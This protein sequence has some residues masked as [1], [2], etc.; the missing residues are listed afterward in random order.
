MKRSTT[1]SAGAQYPICAKVGRQPIRKVAAPT[2]R[3]ENCNS[4]LRPYLSP[5]WPKT[6]P[7]RGRAAKPTAYVTNAARMAS[8][9]LVPFAK[10]TLLNTRVAAVPYRKNSYHSTTVPAIEATTTLRRPE[11]ALVTFIGHI[12]SNACAVS[13]QTPT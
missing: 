1:N 5:K 7:P 8:R 4:F 12:V 3:M 10:N 6:T 11:T 9:S 13:T 2:S